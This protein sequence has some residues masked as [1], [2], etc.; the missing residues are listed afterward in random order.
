[1]YGCSISTVFKGQITFLNKKNIFLND[2]DARFP[3]QENLTEV[4]ITS[5]PMSARDSSLFAKQFQK[6]F[7]R[8]RRV[9]IEATTVLQ[10]G[11][12]F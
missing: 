10:V 9:L 5:D 2:R 11:L 8:K 7:L 6:S 3:K 12:P 4:S 1:M